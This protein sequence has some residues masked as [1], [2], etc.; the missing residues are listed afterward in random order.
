MAE[1]SLVDFTPTPDAKP[2]PVGGP[3]T[4]TAEE[5]RLLDEIKRRESSNNYAAK[6]RGSTASGAY[7]FIN[8]TWRMASHETGAPYYAT[9][10]Q[11]P[12]EVQ[13]QNA[14]HMLRKYGPNATITWSESGPYNAGKIPSKTPRSAP[15]PA[16]AAPTGNGSVDDL[17]SRIAAGENIEVTPQVIAQIIQ[18]RPK[19]APATATPAKPEAPS[20]TLTSFEP[21]P[22]TP[23]APTAGQE[24][25]RAGN[26]VS[27]SSG[28]K[29]FTDLIGGG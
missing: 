17:I 5:A 26:I 25:L 29:F 27:E 2:S 23:P 18:D 12:A 28:L 24:A 20:F 7:Q 13:D 19:P 9:A 4:A 16:S 11:A 10:A 1:L 22:P 8:S 3:R 14:L 21:A 15:A 6:N